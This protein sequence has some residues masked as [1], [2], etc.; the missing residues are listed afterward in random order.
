MLTAVK[1]PFVDGSAFP[2]HTDVI[3]FSNIVS[4]YGISEMTPAAPS[5][6][7]IEWARKMTDDPEELVGQVAEC[8][9]CI[10]DQ[11]KWPV[12]W[13]TGKNGKS[14]GIPW[15]LSVICNLVKNGVPLEDAWTMPESQ[16]IWMNAAFAVANGS[17]ISVVS[18][19]DLKMQEYLARLEAEKKETS[20]V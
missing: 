15:V 8:I 20:N 1:S 9:G 7:D 2:T 19:M 17:D 13:N 10:E 14:S 11:A 3:I 5:K 6:E 4:S 18:D 12:F 16:A